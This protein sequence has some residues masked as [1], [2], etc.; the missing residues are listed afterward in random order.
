[1]RRWIILVL[2]GLGVGAGSV[3]AAAVLQADQCSVAAEEVIEGNLIVLCQQLVVDGHVTGDIVGAAASADINGQVDGSLYLLA[4]RVNVRGAV[5][6]DV[7]F[8]GPVIYLRPDSQLAGEQ[9]DVYSLA[10]TTRIETP[11]P[12]NV[13]GAGYELYIGAPVGGNVHFS[14]TT[15]TINAS[16]EGDVNAS[17]GSATDSTQQL[18]SVTQWFESG[19]ALG[20]PGLTITGVGSV[21]GDMTYRSP[22]TA[23][24]DGRVVGA[25]NFVRTATQPTLDPEAD[26][27]TTLSRYIEAVVRDFIATLIVGLL[28]VV[29]APRTIVPAVQTLYWKIFPSFAVGL[30]TFILAFPA[31]LLAAL[32]GVGI[33]FVI[34]L[35][36]FA[37][38]TTTAAFVITLAIIATAALFFITAVLVSRVVVSAAIGRPLLRRFQRSFNGR[39]EMLLSLALGGLIAAAL[40]ALPAVG[41]LFTAIFTFVGLGGIVLS[42]QRSRRPRE[43]EQPAQQAIAPAPQ[44]LLPRGPG[45]DNLPEG[46]TWWE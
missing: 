43:E 2:I 22:E 19:L 34:S 45:T 18:R 25:L 7:H 4:G 8:A 46:F 40:S 39:V 24:I 30:F 14:G 31:F 29:F 3:S 1:M 44:P 17:V 35:L 33:V 9:S 42:L 26:L 11:V 23:T 28:F 38:F 16:V 21:G 37:D 36:G 27:G 41:I 6:Q 10:L 12:G 15:L 32:V 20:S 13:T 5:G